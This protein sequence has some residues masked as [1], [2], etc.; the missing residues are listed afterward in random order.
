MEY[1]FSEV[2]KEKAEQYLAELKAKRKEILDAGL[3]T[4]EESDCANLTIDDLLCDAVDTGFGI[5]GEAV[6]GYYVT[7]HYD[8]DN[9]Y[10]FVL[11][12]DIVEVVDKLVTT[13]H[14]FMWR[15]KNP[16]DYWASSTGVGWLIR[17]DVIVEGRKLG[18]F[19]GINRTFDDDMYY[20]NYFNTDGKFAY[21]LVDA[22]TEMILEPREEREH[23]N[24]N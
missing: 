13:P 22:D 11:G 21:L 12:K 6:N 14:D 19:Y 2:G 4:V 9:P 18:G 8:S 5:D 17:C 3:D 23:G 7:D 1:K 20:I 10:C 24:F 16:E 15:V